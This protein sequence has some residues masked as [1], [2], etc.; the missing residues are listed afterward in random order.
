[1]TISIQEKSANGKTGAV[2]TTYRA[3]NTSQYGTCPKT[4]GQCTTHCP[5]YGADKIDY[6]YATAVY[7]CVAPGG[8]SW[9][10]S[11]FDWKKWYEAFKPMPS[12]TTFNFSADTME[13]ALKAWLAGV[14]TTVV[15]PK[16]FPKSTWVGLEGPD[17]SMKVQVV[18]CPAQTNKEITCDNCG[19]GAP[20]CARGN[21]TYI[22]AF[23]LHGTATKTADTC[24]AGSGF[25]TGPYWKRLSTRQQSLSD[26]EMI[27]ALR[28]RLEKR[29]GAKVRF[30]VA[31]DIGQEG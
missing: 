16:D 15:V 31:G 25:R 28:A 8:V 1:M 9:L 13:Q 23:R 11:H 6:G 20:L 2:V 19:D 7:N 5:V 29:P 4:C 22:I 21:R 14:P 30:H 12:K 24:Y 26:I 17:D 3:G 18:T 27:Q 10:Y